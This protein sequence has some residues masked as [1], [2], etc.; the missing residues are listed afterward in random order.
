VELDGPE[1]ECSARF[2]QVRD[3]CA[4]AGGRDIRIAGSEAERALIW[5]TRKAAFA[6]WDGSPRPTTCRTA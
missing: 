5:K 2:D 3:M 1:L 6:A 4:Q